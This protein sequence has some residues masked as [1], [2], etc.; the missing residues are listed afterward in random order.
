[1]QKIMKNKVRTGLG[2]VVTAVL[3]LLLA[4]CGK[5]KGSEDLWLHLP[6]DEGAGSTVKDISGNMAD[7]TVEYIYS[8]ALYMENQDPQWKNTGVEGSSLLFDG[9]SNCIT[10]RS[11]EEAEKENFSVQVWVAP[12]TFEWDDPKAAENGTEQL[13][14]LISR[15]DKEKKQGF[16]LGYQRFGRLCFQVGTGEENLTLWSDK[17][18]LEKYRW[19]LVTAVFDGKNGEMRLYLNGKEISSQ[20]FEAGKK[21]IFPKN[22]DL[23]IGRNPAS[24]KLAAGYVNAF[25]GLMDEMKVYNCARSSEDIQ[26][27]YDSVEAAEIPFEDLWLQN[28]LTEDGYKTQYHGGPYQNWMNEP[29]APIYYN[30]RY[31]LF[32]QENLTGPYWRNICWGHLVSTDMVNWKPV[33]E[34]IT[35]TE[36]SVV[37]DGVWSGGAAYDVNGVPLLFFTAGNDSYARD[38]LISNQNIG[39]AYPADLSDKNLTEWVICKDLA[40]RQEEGQ[41]RT[42]EF[43]DPHIWKEGHV[44]CM[45]IC[46]GSTESKGGTAVLYETDTLELLPDGTVSMDWKYKGPVYEM[47]DQPVTYGTSWELPVILPVTNEAGTIKKYMFLIS[48]APASVADNKVYYFLGDFDVESGKFIPDQSFDNKPSLLDYGTNVFTGPSAF[49]DPVSGEVCLFSIMQDQRSGA[50]E[51]AAGWAHCVGLTRKIWLNDE[52]TDLMMSPVDSLQNLQ[53]EVLLDETNLS[54]K[55]VNEKLA[56]I[57]GDMLYIRTVIDG[58][59]ATEFGIHLKKGNSKDVTTYSYQ[60]EDQTI[61]MKTANKGDAASGNSASGS[62][63]LENGRL[64][65]EIYIDRSL[66]EGFFNDRKSISVRSYTKDIQSQELEFFADKEIVIDNIYITAMNSIFS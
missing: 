21:I 49:I 31:H 37:P 44:W 9:F 14:G 15:F 55:K 48:P 29:H 18:H 43:R 20:K 27:Y 30:G 40:V 36:D 17:D 35:P 2:I 58:K 24:E 33:K 16:I 7:A 13:T 38:G 47:K 62:L 12:R 64:S 23:V 51:G 3:S 66:I 41:G 60:T 4:S 39:V 42:G 53:G 28:I 57:K 1:M 32:F 61:S 11:K 34:A 10:Y 26:K 25:C 46:S 59:E 54:L 50:Y 65:M 5:S 45:L 52:G 63:A 19:N 6:F 8:N 22:K 56:D